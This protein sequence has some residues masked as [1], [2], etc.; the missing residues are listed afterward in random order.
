MLLPCCAPSNRLRLRLPSSTRVYRSSRAQPPCPEGRTSVY[1]AAA[2]GGYREEPGHPDRRRREL[3]VRRL[4]N[5]R[6][7]RQPRHVQRVGVAPRPGQAAHPGG[8]GLDCD[9]RQRHHLELPL[10]LG[11]VR[12]AGRCLRAA[13]AAGCRR[14]AVPVSQGLRRGRQCLAAQRR[15]L[16]RAA[17]HDQQEGGG[18]RGLPD[19][20]QLHRDGGDLGQRGDALRPQPGHGPRRVLGHGRP[21]R[22]VRRAQHH[23]HLRVGGGRP[24]DLRRP[25][26]HPHGTVRCRRRGADS[27]PVD[28]DGELGAAEH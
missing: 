4:G 8:L 25:H 15:H 24:G 16:H 6:P 11:P 10:R 12:G 13:G 14:G 2:H 22:R 17:Q 19:S 26:G 20:A 21:A 23:R 27:R 28:A 3:G 9:L 7:D 1:T 18:E 5:G